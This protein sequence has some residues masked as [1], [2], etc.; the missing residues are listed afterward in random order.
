MPFCCCGRP[1]N[2]LRQAR[3]RSHR[4]CFF[5]LLVGTPLLCQPLAAQQ[6]TP[7]HTRAS[8]A[9]L[10]HFFLAQCSDCRTR[11][12]PSGCL[13]STRGRKVN[14]SRDRP[15]HG[16]S[17]WRCGDDQP[18]KDEMIDLASH[19]LPRERRPGDRQA[20]FRL[21][22]AINELRGCEDGCDCGEFVDNDRSW[23]ALAE[24][25]QQGQIIRSPCFADRMA[26]L[27]DHMPFAITYRTVPLVSPFNTKLPSAPL[28]VC[29]RSQLRDRWRVRLDQ[30]RAK[31]PIGL[32]WA[33]SAAHVFLRN[34]AIGHV[35]T[36]DPV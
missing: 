34:N 11:R 18:P 36:R 13:R 21:R 16:I 8:Q 31:H 2:A 12:R 7:A 20:K 1:E 6:P 25:R 35:P 3:F 33:L 9:V 32:R 26:A 5:C 30:A 29:E 17:R 10:W 27:R 24:Y 23:C 28:W 4:D 14:R 19:S 22:C 15:H